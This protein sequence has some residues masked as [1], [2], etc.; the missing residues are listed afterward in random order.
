MESNDTLRFLEANKVETP[1]GRLNEFV[2]V[3]PTDAKLGTLD[4]VVLSPRERQVRYL[5]VKAGGWFG[6]RYLLPATPA[7]LESDRRALQVDL[8]PADLDELPRTD[9]HQFAAF[10]DIDVVD[11]IFGATA[12]F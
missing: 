2:L 8:E 4:G 11:S 10:R 9:L 1:A 3:S 7:R 5:V 12:D 6:R